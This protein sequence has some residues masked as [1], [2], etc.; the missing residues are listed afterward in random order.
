MVQIDL[1]SIPAGFLPIVKRAVNGE[2]IVICDDQHPVVEMRPIEHPP[3]E[4]RPLGLVAGKIENLPEFFDSL[5][6][7]FTRAF[8]MWKDRTDISTD[9]A[10]AA[11]ELRRKAWDRDRESNHDS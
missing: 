4:E 6:D 1:Q 11:D 10:T 2:T 5:P 7:E 9:S 3:A 8:G